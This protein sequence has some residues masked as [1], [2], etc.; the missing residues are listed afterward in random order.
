M[1]DGYLLALYAAAFAT[2]ATLIDKKILFKE[3]ALEYVTTWAIATFIIVTPFLIWKL[4]F[5]F[6]NYF[7]LVMLLIGILNTTG[8]IYLTKTF[9]HLE[10]SV[11]SPLMGFEPAF[12]V[13]LA[14][15]FLNETVSYLQMWGLVLILSGG[16][17]LEIRKEK[18]SLLQPLKEMINSKYIHYGLLAIVCYGTS[19]VISRYILNPENNLGLNIFTYFFVIKFFTAFFLLALL[20]ILYDGIQGV[21][22]GVKNMGWL[23]IP[24][25][26]FSIFHGFITLYAISLPAVNVGLIMAV[27]RVSIFFETLI[28]GELFHDHNLFLKLISSIVMIAGAYLIIAA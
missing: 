25:I 9:R 23:L 12:I 21:K 10:I 1:I 20:S 13:L 5:N 19:S 27:K 28:G 18:F 26:F 4:D 7:W 6:P 15:L 17:L 22:N 2:I 16:Y 3:H 8:A 11:A 14:F 24:A